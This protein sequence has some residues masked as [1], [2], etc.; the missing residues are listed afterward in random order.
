MIRGSMRSESQPASG[1]MSDWTAGWTTRIRPAASTA[2]PRNELEIEAEQKRHAER[3]AVVDERGQ[4]RVDEHRVL[5][6]EP[7]IEKGT[8]GARLPCEEYA[9]AEDAGHDERDAEQA[10]RAREADH[11]R[12]QRPDVQERPDEI[13]PL[14]LRLGPLSAEVRRDQ[15]RRAGGEGGGEEED[16]APADPRGQQ[17]SHEW[18]EREPEVHAGHGDPQRAAESR[19][20]VDGG[21]DRGAGSEDERAARTLQQPKSDQHLPGGSDRTEEGGY[22]EH[23]Q[24]GDE[25]ASSPDDVGEA[26]ERQQQGG[27]RQ[28][29]GAGDPS[30]RDRTQAELRRDGRERNGHGRPHEGR[31]EAAGRR[32]DEGDTLAGCI[33]RHSRVRA[34]H[35]SDAT[36]TS[37]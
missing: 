13:E 12:D 1:E 16:P 22:G 2:R 27:R 17:P 25:D 19:P 5:A 24:P 20:R 33:S 7:E 10:G 29:E 9:E 15:H 28:E 18:T 36:P 8:R 37:R 35:T 31:Q 4:V 32:R 3:G 23:D 26:P 34:R 21:E 11:E 30:E 14:S 6:E